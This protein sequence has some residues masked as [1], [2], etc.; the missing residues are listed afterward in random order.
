MSLAVLSLSMAA[1]AS[2]SARKANYA[3]GG[4]PHDARSNLLDAHMANGE[5]VYGRR[6]QRECGVT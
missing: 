5:A 4:V 6:L 1:D 3:T 2:V